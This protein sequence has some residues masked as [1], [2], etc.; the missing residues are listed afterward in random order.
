MKEKI[1]EILS[2]T[3]PEFDFTENGI[4]F[5]KSGYL[6]SFDVI[7][8]V[9]DLEA[10]FGIKINGALILPENFQDIDSIE[11]LIESSK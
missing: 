1:I 11:N 6:D 9:A 2:D 7:T 10:A 4:D 8:I 5:I 3:R